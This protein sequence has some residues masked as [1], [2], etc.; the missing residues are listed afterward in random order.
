MQAAAIEMS[1]QD[2]KPMIATLILM[3]EGKAY[4]KLLLHV[5][6]V[7]I[8]VS[9]VNAVYTQTWY[10]G[11]VDVEYSEGLPKGSGM[12]VELEVDQDLSLIHI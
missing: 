3:R 9:L 6:Q 8:L 10:T 4:A 2:L 1:K 12:E 7:L 5:A 11:I